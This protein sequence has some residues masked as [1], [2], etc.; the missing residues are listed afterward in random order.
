MPSQGPRPEHTPQA[1]QGVA[2]RSGA[3]EAVRTAAGRPP[4]APE[5]KIL[6]AAVE[7]VT[8][9]NPENGFC[10]LRTRARGPR[11]LVTVVGDAATVAPGERITGVGEWVDD[12]T[13]GQHSGRASC[14]RRSR[15]RS[16]GSSGTRAPA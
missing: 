1:R 11:D 12:C 8:Y 6:A 10:V 13:R 7:R 3:P 14:G 2:R 15:R 16:M 4:E 9:E 5:R